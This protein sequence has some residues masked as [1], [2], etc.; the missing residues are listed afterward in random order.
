M[1]YKVKDKVGLRKAKI[2]LAVKM[3]REGLPTSAIATR[4]SISGATARVL[5]HAG[6]VTGL[7]ASRRR[8]DLSGTSAMRY[9][10]TEEYRY[11]HPWRQPGP[12]LREEIKSGEK[13]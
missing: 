8:D 6:G 2:A 11:G 13:R 3:W 5:L 10:K 4:L 9:S 7:N 12:V 1:D